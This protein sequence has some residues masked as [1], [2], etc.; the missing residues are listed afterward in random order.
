MDSRAKLMKKLKQPKIGRYYF[1]AVLR[2]LNISRATFVQ[3]VASNG[4][5][6]D[7]Q[8]LERVQSPDPTFMPC[9]DIFVYHS[10]EVTFWI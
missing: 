5:G 7:Y 6:I 2:Q 9:N 1:R 4:N 8:R 3:L 10:L